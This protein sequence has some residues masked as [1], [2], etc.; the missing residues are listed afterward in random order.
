MKKNLS[1][2]TITDLLV[3][4]AL[5]CGEMALSEN[6]VGHWKK[7]SMYVTEIEI[8]IVSRAKED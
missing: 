8:E 4:H 3:E 6:K 2:M 5:A 7:L 1:E